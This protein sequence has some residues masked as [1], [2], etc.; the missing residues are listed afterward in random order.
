[1]SAEFVLAVVV[2]GSALTGGGRNPYRG[3]VDTIDPVRGVRGW[4]VDIG[5]PERPVLLELMVGDTIVGE[6]STSLPRRDISNAL[7]KKITPGFAFEPSV[8]TVIAELGHAEGEKISVR[9]AGSKYHLGAKKALQDIEQL[10]KQVGPQATG[11]KARAKPGDFD[12]L[13]DNLRDTAAGMAELPLR[14]PGENLAGYVETMSVG[15]D[16]QVW[17]FGWMKRGHAH[18]FP[19]V[20]NTG[21]GQF[22]VAIATLAYTRADVPADACG[23]VGLISG[24]WTPVNPGDD[25]QIFFGAD[26]QNFLQSHRP[27]RIISSDELLAEYDSVRERLLGVG[28]GVALQRKLASLESWVATRAP[29]TYATETAIDRILMVPGLGCLVEGWVISPMKRIEGLKL[30]LGGA[31]MTAQ[32]NATY[33]KPRRD[34]VGVFPNSESVIQKAGFVALFAGEAEPE[35]F[36]DPMLKVLFQGGTSANFA[37]PAKV[38]RR[39]GHSASLDDALLFFPALEEE[40]F[41]P[42]F[43][44]SA[45]KA[46]RMAM[47]PPVKLAA[48]R[49]RRAMIFVLPDDRCDLFLLF[50]ELA[51]Q[52]RAAAPPEAV[53]FIASA[54]TNRSDALWLFR[55]FQAS[56]TVPASLLVIDDAAQAFALL[57]DILREI[58]AHRFVFVGPGTFLTQKGWDQARLTLAEAGPEIVFLGLEA[59]PYE[60]SEGHGALSAA[61]FAWAAPPFLRWAT[62]APSFL[63]GIYRDNGLGRTQVAHVVHRNGAKRLRTVSQGRIHEAV[64]AEIY[65]VGMQV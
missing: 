42:R 37:V 15:G 51:Q 14:A 58:G 63:G 47:N 50:E 7:G 59:D 26:G 40:V 56:F 34:L 24:G 4:A 39:L 11:E 1:L 16:G 32:A 18:E 49:C 17:V 43:A 27:L 21:E 2:V 46:Q 10:L 36:T 54:R 22:P 60:S 19:A 25:F 8:L 57:P 61:A 12:Q 9:V 5:S 62:T 65:K 33:W 35:D 44:D 6:T 29:Q 41:F 55:E 38:F 53:A 52:C 28:R 23:I 20:V 3:F 30:R 64:N 45:I 13:L 48:S 31:V